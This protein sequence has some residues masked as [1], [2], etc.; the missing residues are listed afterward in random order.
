MVSLLEENLVQEERKMKKLS[1]NTSEYHIT[2][3]GF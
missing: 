3:F 1:T 2:E